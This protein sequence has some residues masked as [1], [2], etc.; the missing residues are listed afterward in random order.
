MV[1]RG[2]P[3]IGESTTTWQIQRLKVSEMTKTFIGD[4]RTA[5]EID[6]LQ[7]PERGQPRSSESKTKWQ[8]QWLKVP[9]MTKTFIGDLITVSEIDLLQVPKRG[10][11]CIG[12]STGNMTD[13]KIEGSRDDE[14][15]H[16]WSDGRIRYRSSWG[17]RERPALHRWFEN[18]MTDSKI[19]AFQ[20]D[21]DQYQWSEDSMRDWSPWGSEIG[22]P[23]IGESTTTGQI[24]SP[25]ISET[26]QNLINYFMIMTKIQGHVARQHQ[27]AHSV[28]KRIFIQSIFERRGLVESHLSIAPREGIDFFAKRDE[29]HLLCPVE[30]R[31]DEAVQVAWETRKHHCQDRLSAGRA[32]WQEIWGHSGINSHHT[33]DAYQ[34]EVQE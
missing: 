12:E 34:R 19:E 13:P 8:I 2:R 22:Q 10:Q 28:S 30:I 25:N 3:C 33:K 7:I 29:D 14:D 17:S 18:S 24:Q 6:L 4:L 26:D 23:C 15:L 20:D 5:W 1:T 31:I 21:E 9:E 27:R 32:V 16:R 11:A